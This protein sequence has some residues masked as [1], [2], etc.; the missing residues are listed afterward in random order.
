[1]YKIQIA[2]SNGAVF[3]AGLEEFKEFGYSAEFKDEGTFCGQSLE[4]FFKSEGQLEE[5]KNDLFG[6]LDW[7]DVFPLF[8]CVKYVRNREALLPSFYENEFSLEFS[9]MSDAQK[10]ICIS[11]VA[12]SGPI[13]EETFWE[14]KGTDWARTAISS[15]ATIKELLSS[16][17]EVIPD[18]ILKAE[19]ERRGLEGPLFDVVNKIC[20]ELPEG[21]EVSLKMEKGSASVEFETLTDSF[22]I[23]SDDMNL[24]GQLEKALSEAKEDYSTSSEGEE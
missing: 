9:G 24:T 8:K 11:I 2:F 6:N 22:N 3:E 12:V 14:I 18:D 7:D 19:F 4:Y 16:I 15:G 20:G 13:K 21:Y 1:M 23:D 10:E 5:F 17:A